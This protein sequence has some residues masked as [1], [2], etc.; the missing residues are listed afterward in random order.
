LSNFVPLI[1]VVALTL[2]LPFLGAWLGG[3]PVGDLLAL[4][5]TQRPWDPWPPEQGITLAANLV[6]IGLLVV[7]VLLARPRR[8]DGGARQPEPA[9]TAMQASW[10]RYGW[11][12]VFALIA[13]VIAWD[14]AAIQ[15]AIALVTLAAMLFAGADTQRRTGTSLIRQRPGYFF[16]LF[17][18]SLV[19]GWTFY[20]VNLFLGLWAY[21][22]ATETVPFVLGKSI[23]YAVLLP[24]ALV[25]RQW[26][27]SFPGVLQ[28]TNRARPLPG[29]AT[30][31]EGWTLLGLGS[32]ALVGAAL[33]PDWLYG[34]TLLAPL[35][36]A[37]GLSQLRGRDTLLAGLG[38][39][40]WSRVLLP[41]AAALL[42]GLIAQGGNA[43]LGPAWVIELPLLGG[44]MLFDLPL[45][46][47]LVI[48][49]LGLL[50]VW[51]AD[52]LTSPWQQRPL[53]PAYRPRFP[54]RVVL[55]DLLQRPKR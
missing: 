3:Q 43:L 26:L 1:V 32:V 28:L 21:P 20:W 12:G 53:Q 39:G 50:G 33:W 17:P 2:L 54:V 37:F 35:L 8:R 45:P 24:A 51:V 52:Q 30:P 14:G 31:Q 25:L 19:L 55:E 23:D 4:P 44:P 47:W 48:A 41:A 13:A 22:G 16:S 42:V 40:D 27:A 36:L 5:L 9:A 49:A 10:P 15:A 38:R 6:S 11:L 34:L 18:A 46:A 7:L 29:R